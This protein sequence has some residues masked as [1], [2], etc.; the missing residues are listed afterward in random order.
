MDIHLDDASF[1]NINNN[2]NIINKTV[3]KKISDISNKLFKSILSYTA[4]TERNGSDSLNSFNIMDSIKETDLNASYNLFSNENLVNNTELSNYDLIN[5]NIDLYA[6]GNSTNYSI[7][8]IDNNIYEPTF[9]SE[10]ILSDLKAIESDLKRLESTELSSDSKEIVNK[11]REEILKFREKIEK[12]EYKLEDV[13]KL[14]SLMKRSSDFLTELSLNKNVNVSRTINLL[15]SVQNCLNKDLINL[16]LNKVSDLLKALTNEKSIKSG[17][18][19]ELAKFLD[20]MI[21]LKDNFKSNE[22]DK[23]SMDDLCKAFENELQ[24]LNFLMEKLFKNSSLKENFKSTVS[25]SLKNLQALKNMQIDV[26]DFRKIKKQTLKESIS[27]NKKIQG[28]LKNNNSANKNTVENSNEIKTELFI[29]PSN[30][31]SQNVENKSFS[32]IMNKT[33][34]TRTIVDPKEIMSQLIKKASVSLRDNK[35][36]IVIQLKP[37]SL[38]KLKLKLTVSEGEVSGKIIVESNEVK[39]ILQNDLTNLNNALEE[40]GLLLNSMDISLGQSYKD[41]QLQHGDLEFNSIEN[42]DGEISKD[43]INS[44]EDENDKESELPEWLAGNINIKG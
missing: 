35:S 11:I 17:D 44:I 39:K 6:S 15:N 29:K 3:D 10:K 36:E 7:N 8:N 41:F 31:I 22:L 34:H 28:D 43:K 42:N 37:E 4:H 14:V 5:Y 32:S 19:L 21:K 38:G 18:K 13:T 40:N 30:D 33:T 25:N 16:E 1:S 12:K 9:D 23:A 20:S 26:R 2:S 27:K 24:K